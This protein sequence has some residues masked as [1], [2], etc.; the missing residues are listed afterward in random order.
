MR[1][2]QKLLCLDTQAEL[3]DDGV[4]LE[5][6]QA[7]RPA[8]LRAI[9]GKKRLDIKDDLPGVYKYSDWLP[10]AR[11][12]KA[13]GA[14]VT[15]PS[16]KL[17]RYLGLRN[18]Y[19]TFNGYWPEIGATMKTGTFKECEAYSVCARFPKGAGTLVV[20]SAGNTARAF[21]KV[22]SENDIP[23]AIVVPEKNVDSLWSLEPLNPCV[24]IVAAGGESDYYDAIRLSNAI[25]GID[26]FV[27][28]GGAK[29]VAR[30]DGMG[31]TVLSAATTIG[32]IPDYYFQ[33]VGSGTGAIAAYEANLRL[34]QSGQFKPKKMRLFVSQ[35]LPFAPMAKAW[36]KKSRTLDPMDDGEALSE[37]DTMVAKVLSNRQPPYGITGGLY[38]ALTGSDG[39]VIAVE[40]QQALEAQQLF[41]EKEGRDICPEAGVALA[42]LMLKL[43]DGALRRGDV[44]MLNIT[45]GGME[46]LARENTLY[47]AAPSLVVPREDIGAETMK[48]KIKSLF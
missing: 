31:T 15:Y 29:N 1:R 34:N 42:S 20:A 5:N 35:N 44:I 38:D 18:L 19:I 28:E 30:R 14:P 43:K 13:D 27:N 9:F 37:I 10:I 11:T 2:R 25:C 36:A 33:A 8:L 32:E 40:N 17:G 23:M 4:I 24:K 22:A 21:M 12:L 48:E 3:I 46:A 39:D 7:K 26:G 16:R 6:P 47:R 41:L 45:G